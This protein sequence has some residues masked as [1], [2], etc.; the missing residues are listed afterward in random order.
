MKFSLNSQ[1]ISNQAQSLVNFHQRF[2]RFFQ[3]KTRCV[4]VTPLDYLKGLFIVDKEKTMA[5]MERQVE[6]SNK[7]RLD[8]FISN[9]PWEDKALVKEI[10]QFVLAELILM[11]KKMLR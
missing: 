1:D 9:S 2:C 6:S 3:T 10:Q 7:Q 11:E 4:T 5:E 8:H